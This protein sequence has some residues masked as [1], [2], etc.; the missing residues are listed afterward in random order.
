MPALEQDKLMRRFRL[1]ASARADY[2]AVED[3]T[4]MMLDAY[5]AGVN[6]FV[7]SSSSLPVEYRII[8]LQPEPWQPWD[9]LLVYKVRHIFMGVFES[10]LW[11][12][13]MVSKLGPERAAKLFPGYQ[14][15]QLL[16]LPPGEIY[17]GPLED[18]LEE[19]SRGAAALNYLNENDSGSNSWAISGSADG[20][21]ETALSR[22]LSPGPG[23]PQRVLPEPLGLSRVRRDRLVLSRLAGVSSFWPQRLGRLV[24]HAY[25]RRL[26][27]PVHRAVQGRRPQVLPPPGAVAQGRSAPSNH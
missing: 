1:E 25:G 9:G 6:A 20:L 22:G 14:P 12:A 3:H 8:G 4:R 27:G 7:D 2:Q 13:R 19:L 23:H 11:R 24:R 10:K 16:I 21:R 26:S 5:A 18:G 17:S 15:G